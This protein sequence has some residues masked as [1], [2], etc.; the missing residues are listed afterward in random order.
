MLKYYKYPLK[1]W[2]LVLAGS[3]PLFYLLKYIFSNTQL[4]D[5]LFELTY[6]NVLIGYLGSL[7][8]CMPFWLIFWIIYVQLIKSG[9]Q[10]TKA[11]LFV[12]SQVLWWLPFYLICFV[13]KLFSGDDFL[14]T[15]APHAIILAVAV[16]IFKTEQG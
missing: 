5:F 8:V 16:L 2:T 7:L 4:E 10:K 3:M 14:L 6:L 13:F 11:Y 9:T 1:V 15:F 12:I